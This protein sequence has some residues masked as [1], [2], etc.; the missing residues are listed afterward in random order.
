[1][2]LSEVDIRAMAPCPI[3]TGAGDHRNAHD[4][5]SPANPA[6]NPPLFDAELIRRYDVHGPRYTSYPTALLF[7]VDFDADAYGPLLLCLHQGDNRNRRH[8]AD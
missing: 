6:D 5:P 3:V 1:M 8:A 2:P 7:R 4:R